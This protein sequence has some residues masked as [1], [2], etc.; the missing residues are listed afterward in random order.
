M[1]FVFEIISQ[2][3]HNA[4]NDLL[5]LYKVIEISL[6]DKYYIISS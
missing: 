6:L 3:L 2:I 5:E 1:D 4:L